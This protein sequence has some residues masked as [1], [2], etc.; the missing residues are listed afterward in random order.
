MKQ[1]VTILTL[2][3]F[4]TAVFA[5]RGKVTSALSYKESGDIEKAFETIEIAVDTTNPRAD[6]SLDWPR[7]WEV[8]G[9]ILQ[10]VHKREIKGLIDEPLFEAFKSYKRAIEL[11]ERS[12]LSKSLVIDLTFL[13]TDLSN[14][15][16]TSYNNGNFETAQKC[17]EYFMEI[18]NLPIMKESAA[19]EVIDT[20]IIY[21]AG[22]AA[23]KAENYE[24]SID[25]FKKAAKYDYNG[26]SCYN[27]IYQA[28]QLMGDT[29]ASINSLKEGF[30]KYPTDEI[31]I[32]E[33]INFYISK[34]RS[35]EAIDYIELAI[36]EKPDNPSL[37]TAK[38]GML[39][40]L[41]RK[42]E[43][44]EM[45]KEAIEVDPKQ[46]T[47]YYNL[48]VIYYNRGVEVVNEANKIPPSETEKYEAEIEKAKEH[49]RQSLPY[50]EKAYSLD[51]T[52]IAI[53]ESLKT[54]YYRLKMTDKYNEINK[55]IQN[56][57]KE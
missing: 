48:S 8:R 33:L 50:I 4:S 28:H 38:G 16:I 15:A 5:Q 32:V 52:E 11:D 1:L 45:Y 22:L 53:L 13:Q 44:I 12:R 49:F 19:Q 42:E 17:F 25:Y 24:T 10:E 40:K 30:E 6:R 27:F 18:S 26:G 54:I 20:A 23:F 57:E 14:Y 39:E 46:F 31:L 35:E 9:Q 34:G 47:P 3:L 51:S 7:T 56:L 41:G 37:Y 43:A 29:L 36:K 55:K 21:N 2:I